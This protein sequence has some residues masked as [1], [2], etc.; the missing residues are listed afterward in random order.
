MTEPAI[1]KE[2]ECAMSRRTRVYKSKFSEMKED[3]SNIGPPK[4]I[5]QTHEYLN[6]LR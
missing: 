4:T 3:I 1:A 5:C 2:Q 6:R